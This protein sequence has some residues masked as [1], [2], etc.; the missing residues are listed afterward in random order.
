MNKIILVFFLFLM[1]KLALSKSLE[2]YGLNKLSMN[3]LQTLTTINL[4]NTELSIQDVN[5]ILN[6]LYASEIIYNIELTEEDSIFKI[7]IEENKLIQNIF[8]NNNSWIE[9]DVIFDI[10]N[11][12]SNS[13]ILKST[14]TNDI[15]NINTVYKSKGFNDVSTVAKIE[16]FSDDRVNLIFDIYEGEQSKLNN[17]KFVGNAYFSS[18][19]LSTKITSQDLNFYNIFKSG[20]NLNP[21]VFEFDLNIIKNYYLDKG[22]FDVKTSY[23]VE[24]NSFGLYTLIFY[25]NEGPRYKINNLNYSNIIL[26][27]DF[28]KNIFSDL[29]KDIDQNKYFYDQMLIDDYLKE[30]NLS[31]LNNNIID[32]YIDVKNYKENLIVNINFEKIKQEPKIINKINIY[33]NGITND[34]TIRSKILIEPGDNLNT[35][36]LDNSASNLN[37]FSYIKKVDYNIDEFNQNA[38]LNFTIEEEKKTGNILFAGTF[39]SDTEL[40]FM[41]GIEDKNFAG[42]GNIIDANF[43]INSE[44]IKY[45]I[46]YT[47]FPLSNPFLSNTYSIFNSENDY[48][49]SFGYKVSRQGI[50]YSLSF[51]DSSQIS[52]SVG[53]SYESLKG[54]DPKDSSV[55]SINDNIGQFENITLRTNIKK[56]TTNDVF[57]PTDGHYNSLA[58]TIS[59][60]EIS[61]DPFYK[62]IFTNKNYFKLK[63][64]ENYIFFNNNLGYAESLKSKLKTINS[65]SLGGNNFKGFDFR[66]IG[67]VSNNIYLGGNKFVTS[68][69]G[70]GSSFIFDDKDNINIKLFISSGSIWDSDYTSDNKFDLRSSA[71]V[72]LDFITAIGPISFSYA[73]PIN[74]KSSDRE[75]NFAFTIGTSF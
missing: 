18:R 40:G 3:D 10:I 37:K 28:I 8:I 72:S 20:S 60:S 67:P 46:N 45:D 16:S 33:G 30:I 63:D 71:G 47:Q 17:I 70:Y 68:T 74:K 29:E 24:K 58:L 62:L 14:I 54:H 31:L 34:Q 35:Y 26:N 53:F 66:G 41:F 57:N 48:T 69:L 49:S 1:P 15:N 52:Y 59:P 75:R 5:T 64:S 11:S 56:D 50:G 23:T 38:D 13:F 12:K 4:N 55:S 51:A 2:I 7:V 22:F 9:D 65:F 73:S 39:D 61:D 43:N 44:N 25:I 32:Y 6:E 21:E 36:L 42:S 27:N 19:F